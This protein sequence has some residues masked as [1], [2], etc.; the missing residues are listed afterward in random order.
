MVRNRKIENVLV[1]IVCFFV[2]ATACNKEPLPDSAYPTEVDSNETEQI[3]I[4]TS[5]SEDSAVL[6][7][8]EYPT[9]L[10]T[11]VNSG[12]VNISYNAQIHC[13]SINNLTQVT[14]DTDEDAVSRMH[15]VYVE[16]DFVATRPDILGHIGY[17]VINWDLNGS[18]SDIEHHWDRYYISENIALGMNQTPLEA[19]TALADELESYTCLELEPRV[20]LSLND[21]S[22]NR[23]YYDISYEASYNDIPLI[24][25]NYTNYNSG[26]VGST[27]YLSA[28][29][30]PEGV[31]DINGMLTYCVSEEVPY[32]GLLTFEQAISNF[33]ENIDSLCYS[34]NVIVNEISIGY[35][36]VLGDDAL[37]L[38]PV[39]VFDCIDR[40]EEGGIAYDSTLIVLYN[41]QTGEL[42]NVG[43]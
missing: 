12:G 36:P 26:E 31:F 34:E 6:D 15:E 32:E 25:M 17:L 40:I 19:A 27:Y 8:L 3:D 11:S 33:E 24:E 4:S 41:L 37:V 16:G 1:T 38:K 29:I 10:N 22:Q 30:C 2:F 7:L 23:G 13:E 21:E 28:R 43:Y 20:V 9:V 39:L 35:Y 5:S 18:G 14:L 42:E